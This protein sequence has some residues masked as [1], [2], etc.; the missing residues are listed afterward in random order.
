MYI[1]VLFLK[2]VYVTSGFTVASQRNYRKL[3]LNN[4]VQAAKSHSQVY[5]LKIKLASS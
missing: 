2:H 1:E 3:M 5:S 4:K